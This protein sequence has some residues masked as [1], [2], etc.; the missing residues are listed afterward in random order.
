[1]RLLALASVLS[2][3]VTVQSAWAGGC[4]SCN[5]NDNGSYKSYRGPACSSPPGYALAPG[6]CTCQPSA[7]DNA[8]DGYCEEKA[9]WQAYFREVGKPKPHHN[10]SVPSLFSFSASHPTPAESCNTQPGNT[11]DTAPNPP[12]TENSPTPALPPAPKPSVSKVTR[13]PVMTPMR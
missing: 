7:C 6:C 9:K 10:I 1:M 12:K 2:L 11:I 4:A 8:W 13:F 5:G 3:L